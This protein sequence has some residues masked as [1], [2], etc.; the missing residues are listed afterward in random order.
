MFR[1]YWVFLLL[2]CCI[3]RFVLSEPSCQ[4][5][6]VDTGTIFFNCAGF[7]SVSQLATKIPRPEPNKHV[8]SLSDSRLES[9]PVDA[10][11]GLSASNV[12]F[13]NVHVDDFDASH[14]NAFER[15]NGTLVELIFAG[16]STLPKSWSLLQHVLSLTSLHFEKQAL[17]VDHDWS[18]LPRSLRDIFITESTVSN[19]EQGALAALTS[20]EQFR[21]TGS[22]LRNFSWSLLPSPAR[23][24]HTI[25]L[26]QNGLT[27]IPKGFNPQQFPALRSIHLESNPITTWSGETLDAIRL[28][29]NSPRL[30]L[31]AITC[32][33]QVRALR[34]FPRNRISATCA[35]PEGWRYQRIDE[36][37][38]DDLRC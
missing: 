6:E 17:S 10:F 2:Q 35:S 9:L 8:F 30:I 22:G 32:D 36:I 26:S 14:P 11:D 5:F 4:K 1:T 18:N 7:T 16:G 29:P 28:H 19:L 27:E 25:V 3:V 34:E 21:I 13:N 23:S 15:L 31:G 37:N 33:C 12:T 38:V 24:L 20:L